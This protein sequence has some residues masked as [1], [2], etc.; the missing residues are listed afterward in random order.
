M[1]ENT[2]KIEKYKK[3]IKKKFKIF[4]IK[5][6]PKN[7]Y[8]FGK[9]K[10]NKKIKKDDIF[11][12]SNFPRITKNKKKDRISKSIIISF[13]FSFFF[14]SS[15]INSASF[16]FLFFFVFAFGERGSLVCFSRFSF[17]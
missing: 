13:S 9:K 2:R 11:S 12:L 7:W 6:L 5:N 16:F 8:F 3:I 1:D 15:N 14:F 10:Y 17:G 4:K